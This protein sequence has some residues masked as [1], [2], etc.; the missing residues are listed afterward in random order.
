MSDYLGIDFQEVDL[1]YRSAPVQAV[2]DIEGV[3]MRLIVALFLVSNLLSAI[4]VLPA[5]AS[6]SPGKSTT[7]SNG[8]T[9]VSVMTFNVANLFDT[10]HDLGKD[11]WAFLPKAEK[12][13][14]VQTE[15]AKIRVFPWR[16]EC[17][18]LDW[19]ESLLEMKMHNIA[20]AIL[21]VNGGRGAD[22]LIL[23]EVENLDVLNR[24]NDSY[25]Q[26]AGYKSVLLI[27]GNDDR[28]IDQAILSRLPIQGTA[29]NTWIPLGENVKSRKQ[30]SRT[31]GLLQVTLTLPDN[32]PLE[33]FAVHFPSGDTH[34]LRVQAIAFLNKKKAALPKGRLS[35][36][37]GDFNINSEEDRVYDVYGTSLSPWMISHKIGCKGCIGTEYYKTKRE[38]SFLDA[39]GFSKDLEL[40][41]NTGWYVDTDSIQ[42][43]TYGQ[44][45]MT[46]DGF[47]NRFANGTGCSDHLPMFAILKKDR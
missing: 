11:D 27:E 32:T 42:I 31:R 25:L 7:I 45:Q 33:V 47:P 29:L 9:E 19:T 5:L 26:R 10:K 44:F 15:C 6:A 43:P 13:Q 36:V 40:A 21:S 14:T 30:P 24:F 22:I 17:L 4:T 38:W 35:I 20:D 34:N 1:I 41:K 18:N 2:N 37:G 23:Q 12:N 28:G 3:Q 39:I 46:V 16:M 8:S